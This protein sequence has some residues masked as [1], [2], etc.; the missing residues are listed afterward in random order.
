MTSLPER[1]KMLKIVSLCDR[2]AQ[3]GNKRATVLNVVLRDFVTRH[4]QYCIQQRICQCLFKTD[5]RLAHRH[6]LCLS[7]DPLSSAVFGMVFLDIG[8]TINIK[9]KIDPQTIFTM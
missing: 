9:H 7:E 3:T 1:D 8:R 5:I 6:S 2:I 4:L